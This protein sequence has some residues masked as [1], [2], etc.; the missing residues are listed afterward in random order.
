[1]VKA[2]PSLNWNAMRFGKY[3]AAA[4]NRLARG[5]R[6]LARAR[7]VVTDRLHVHIISLLMGKPHAVLDNSYGKIARFMA[8]FS[9]NNDLSYR[10][11][12]LDDA[13][14]WAKA[15]AEAA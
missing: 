5:V 4:N 6:Q 2:L 7:V 1:M 9:G 12:S 8:A 15:R 13:I 14:E 10:A 11:T 3:D